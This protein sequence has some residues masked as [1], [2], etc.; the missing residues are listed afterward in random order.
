M[1]G[2]STIIDLALLFVFLPIAIFVDSWRRVRRIGWEWVV[3]GFLTMSVFAAL[4]EDIIFPLLFPDRTLPNIIATRAIL[5]AGVLIF[6]GIYARVEQPIL[7]EGKKWQIVRSLAAGFISL[8]LFLSIWHA[9]KAANQTRVALPIYA[10]LL[11]LG[12]IGFVSAQIG[13]YA[14]RDQEKI[15]IYRNQKTRKR[16]Q[17]Y[18]STSSDM[19]SCPK[20]GEGI[21]FEASICPHCAYQFLGDEIVGLETEPEKLG[22]KAGIV[23]KDKDCPKC[24]EKI[25]LKASICPYCAYQFVPDE[26]AEVFRPPE[27]SIE[28]REFFV[29][30]NKEDISPAVGAGKCP[31]CAKEI[32]LNARFC[33][34]C[35][36]GL[37][38]LPIASPV[39]Q[40]GQSGLIEADEKQRRLT[41]S[42]S[43]TQD[44]VVG[45]IFSF[46]GGLFLI[47]ILM[48]VFSL[49]GRIIVPNFV[50]ILLSICSSVGLLI[51]CM[52]IRNRKKGSLK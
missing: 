32:V 23:D 33:P 47:L 29:R 7:W 49:N 8:M 52:G 31:K 50:L 14:R 46:V 4:T 22:K 40:E 48:G 35:E 17:R 12:A 13:L 21:D 18:S 26:I 28:P 6:F 25:E 16:K 2:I 1:M 37:G 51:F 30:I 19:K 3:F 10:W 39:V 44:I 5:L 42:L 9:V 43:V 11:G 24:G 38:D 15:A 45:G 36:Q 20:C 41:S 34:Y 27:E